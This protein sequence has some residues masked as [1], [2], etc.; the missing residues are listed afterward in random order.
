MFF[1]P[2]FI[3]WKRLLQVLQS[4]PCS[5]IILSL[6]T[7]TFVLSTVIPAASAQPHL[8]YYPFDVEVVFKG[9]DF[10]TSMSFLGPSDIL[11]LEKEKGMVHRIQNGQ[12]SSQPLLDVSVASKGERGM[13]GIAVGHRENIKNDQP[14]VYLF[15]TESAN[16]M[17]GGD[18][19]SEPLGNRIYRY[20]VDDGN[21]ENGKLLL[22]LPDELTSSVMPYHNGGFVLVGPDE[23]IYTVI[24]DLS[25]RKT[26][27][28]NFKDGPPPDG[29]SA[30]FRIDKEGNPVDG[31]PFGNIHNLDKYY[32]Y[33]IHNSFGMDIDP[34]SGNLWNTENGPGYGDEINLV[35]PGFN[36][37]GGHIYGMSF[38]EPKFDSTKLVHF[39]GKGKY[40]DPEF[41]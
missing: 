19:V 5:G 34:V 25:T 3:K 4:Y 21:L 20:S 17:D 37:G 11:V 9:L 35:E 7:N 28:Q 14:D 24:G 33:G 8:N 23:T 1:S 26:Q 41:V 18:I 6:L 31:N 13:L 22:D 30:I 27:A 10:P 39:E 16:N 32:A 2:L 12:M 36:S 38:I 15:F 29:T 40:S